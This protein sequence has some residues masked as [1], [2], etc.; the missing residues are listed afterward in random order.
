[1][2]ILRRYKIQIRLNETEKQSFTSKSYDNN[3]SSNI[4]QAEVLSVEPD[5]PNKIDHLHDDVASFVKY[6]SFRATAELR[7]AVLDYCSSDVHKSTQVKLNYGTTI[8]D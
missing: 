7:Q 4:I 2:R 5:N 8:N 6:K 1:M 3:T